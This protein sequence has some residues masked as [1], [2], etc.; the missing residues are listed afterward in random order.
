MT[1]VDVAPA[2]KGRLEFVHQLRGIAALVVVFGAHLLGV[3]WQRPRAWTLLDGAHDGAGVFA[4]DLGHPVFL[5]SLGG[6]DLRAKYRRSS[7]GLL[8]AVIHLLALTALLSVVMS[9]VFGS[10][11]V[12]YAPYIFR[13]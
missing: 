10:P 12:E 9:R 7:L 11:I 2:E 13:G 6:A 4:E 1:A 8:W 5:D 3:S